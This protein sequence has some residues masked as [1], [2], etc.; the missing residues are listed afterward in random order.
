MNY[1]TWEKYKDELSNETWTALAKWP[2]DVQDAMRE[3]SPDN[4]QLLT[5]EGLWVDRAASSLYHAGTAYRVNPY[6]PGPEKP[7]PV[8]E[9]VDMPVFLI[10]VMYWFTSPGEDGG[11]WRLTAA[12]GVVGFAGYVYTGKEGKPECCPAPISDQQTDGTWRLRV[13]LAV[14]LRKEVVR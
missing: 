13:P 1:A 8:P 7:D 4:T 6:W 5:Y 9:Y 12:P 3:L 10:G 14:R 11:R 2:K